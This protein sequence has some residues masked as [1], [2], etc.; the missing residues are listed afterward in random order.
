M[1]GNSYGWAWHGGQ[2]HRLKGS[3]PNIGEASHALGALGLSAGTRRTFA[4][5]PTNKAPGPECLISAQTASRY[6]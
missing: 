3:H 6:K 2:W 5:H 1:S 4:E